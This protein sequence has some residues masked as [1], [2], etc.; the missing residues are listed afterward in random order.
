[1]LYTDATSPGTWTEVL[2]TSSD[3]QDWTRTSAS[4]S[5]RIQ[6]IV[7]AVDAA[8]NVAVSNNEGVDFNAL[9]Q[10]TTTLSSS[11]NPG[12]VGQQINF[13][14]TVGAAA[15]NVGNPTGNVEFLD[16]G[17]PIASCGGASGTSLT[18]TLAS[19][20]VTYLSPGLHQITATY[21]GSNAFVGSTTLAPV[22][23]TVQSTTKISASVSLSAT[24]TT[25]VV[26]QSDTYTATVS[27]PSG[28]ATPTGT[29]SF[30]DGSSAISCSG[31][32]QILSGS[33]NSATATCQVSY[34]STVGSP[35]SI[36]AVYVPGSDPNYL[37]ASPSGAVTV[38]VGPVGAS[39]SLSATST[40]PVVGQSDTYTATVSGP[41][42]GATPT[43]TVSF[44]DGSSAISCAGGDQTLSGSSNS[45][46]ATCQVS[47]GSTVGSPHSITAVYVP[48][49]DPNYTAGSPS[50]A[51]N[52]TVSGDSST[53]AL[54]LSKA[55]VTY[56]AENGETFTVTVTGTST[57][58]PTG[59]VSVKTG[60]VTLCSTTNLT[61]KTSSSVTATCSLSPAEQAAGTYS[62]TA[63]Y[64]GDSY[65][66]G[67]TSSVQSLSVNQDSTATVLQGLP[68]AVA[69]GS[70]QKAVFGVAVLTG[71]GE[72]LPAT[73][74]ITV[75]VG[76]TSCVA[77]LTPTPLGAVGVCSVASAALP[78]GSYKVSAS[79]AGDIDLKASSGSAVVG[80]TVT[81]AV[82]SISL[83]LSASSVTYGNESSEVFS[84]NVTSSAG[85]PTGTV[86]VGSSAGTL[87]QITLVSG[88]GSCRLTPSQLAGG[89][90]SSV[91][92]SYGA[93][94]NF[95]GS[96]SSPALS[97]T[98]AKD[99]TTT[100]VSESPTKV[101]S[102]AESAAVFTVTVTTAHA[103]AVPSNETVKV[104]VG[105]ASCTATLSGGSGTCKIANNALA[106]GSYAVSATYGGDANLASSSG[107]SS[108]NLTV[109]RS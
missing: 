57:S 9:T 1:M 40:A 43:G 41:S 61:K 67:S 72:P 86:T 44:E 50:A 36:T 34:G 74:P 79:Y 17:D 19:C 39:V 83:S 96:S 2:L 108:T 63:V 97:F 78:V 71:N 35:H 37:A 60:S 4:A 14:A 12:L 11:V 70:E 82:T 84:A 95:A 80:L 68:T 27:G 13:A 5:T 98:V 54:S 58:L 89:T 46:T 62:V 29:V 64:G 21:L 81:G 48:G 53:T 87:C 66:A 26:G 32:D 15:S 94:G 38:T 33:S 99:T 55:S 100:K 69:Y 30:E 7:E 49:S 24:S 18:G 52:V 45:A 59:T 77:S 28:G 8:G 88:S 56:G 106:A 20:S 75:V 31:G 102:G 22:D 65:N 91:V 103:E 109:T 10:T 93:N 104:T 85:T 47:Y 51:L 6:Y 23:E 107:T 3:G 16:D 25:P 101:T 76:T 90:V 105:T 42:G 73:E 92:A